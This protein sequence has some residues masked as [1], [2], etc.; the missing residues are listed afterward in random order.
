MTPSPLEP[1]IYI[2]P[3]L[4]ERQWLKRGHPDIYQDWMARLQNGDLGCSICEERFTFP[5]ATPTDRGPVGLA[6]LQ[7]S[8]GRSVATVCN[9]CASEIHD[10]AHRRMILAMIRQ[11]EGIVDH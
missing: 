9:L 8:A 3:E 11:A 4:S 5:P 6:L 1:Q 10:D 7:R 2:V